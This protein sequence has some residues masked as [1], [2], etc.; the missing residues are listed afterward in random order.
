MKVNSMEI[1]ISFQ[2]SIHVPVQNIFKFLIDEQRVLNFPILNNLVKHL[3]Y[4]S[5]QGLMIQIADFFKL[6]LD[7]D[8]NL[9]AQ[10]RYFSILYDVVIS[11]F[12]EFFQ[13]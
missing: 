12:I 9:N 4:S 5:E 7:R 10:Q 3:M 6:I 11:K 13:L 8:T 1:I 2:Q